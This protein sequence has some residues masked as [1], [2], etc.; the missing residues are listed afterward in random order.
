M[1]RALAGWARGVALALTLAAISACSSGGG[2]PPSAG[3]PPTPIPVPPA[4]NSAPQI[5]GAP[6]DKATVD[7]LFSFQPSAT[8]ADGDK[9][10]FT[11]AGKPSWA[12]FEPTTGR[13]QGTPREA[14]V[15]SFK[16]IAI[17][18]TDGLLSRTL[19]F[20]VTVVKPS[21]SAQ[22]RKANYGHY[23]S[24]RYADNPADAAMLCEQVGVSGVVWRRT[25]KEVEPN[26]GVYDFSSFDDV[27]GAIARSKKPDCQLWL[28]VEFKSF[29]SSPVKNPCPEY[30]QARHSAQNSDGRNATTCFI[31]EPSVADAYIAMM[32]AVAARYDANPRFEGFIFQESSLG[33]NGNYSQDVAAGGTYTAEAWRDSLIKLVSQCG[34][35]FSESRCMA[36]MN[37]MRGGQTYLNDISAAISAI[38][39]NRACF[40]GPDLL[41][42]NA[43]LYN[44]SNS[45][46]QVL[47]RHSGCRSNSAQND[48]FSVPGCGLDCIFR[49]AVGGAFGNFG[50][51]NPL[52]SGVCVNSYLFWNH[53]VGKS[54]TGLDWTDALPVIAANPYA[55]DW[56]KHCR[57]GG[58]A[59]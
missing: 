8:D 1:E 30:V 17:S 21:G 15:G 7:Q 45:V 11:I 57:S 10:S 41:P 12:A 48:S 13:L 19:P 36:F 25:W 37:F 54:P 58:D 31:W 34:A 40:S 23:F 28:I 32:K 35:S 42:N 43:T 4:T 3:Q 46:Y 22:P 14:D 50:E 38:P 26:A 44:N 52:A 51:S 20:T 9:L 5:S 6:S 33:F 16:Q 55:S 24:T 27:L 53:R 47:T 59:P 2:T 56:S 39:D 29:A 18:V 49:F